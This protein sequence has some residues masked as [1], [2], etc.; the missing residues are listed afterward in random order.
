[1]SPFAIYVLVYSRLCLFFWQIPANL[2]L[3]DPLCVCVVWLQKKKNS[4]NAVNNGKRYANQ[5]H[6]L[7]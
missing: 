3:P 1:M 6:G 4:F 7:N 5:K 2:D